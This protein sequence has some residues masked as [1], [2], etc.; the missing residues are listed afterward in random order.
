MTEQDLLDAL[1]RAMSSAD[2]DDS[3]GA[4]TAV[5]IIEVLKIC[6]KKVYR[7]LRPLVISGQVECVKV[8]RANL[9]GIMHPVPA[10]RLKPSLS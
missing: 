7:I 5:E 1:R 9:A 10:Y 8:P 4:M 2:D 6:D 3:D